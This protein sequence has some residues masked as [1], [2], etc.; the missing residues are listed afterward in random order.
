MVID[1]DEYSK[2]SA[3]FAENNH[4]GSTGVCYFKHS[5][6]ELLEFFGR[7]SGEERLEKSC[8]R[9]SAGSHKHIEINP[10]FRGMLRK[11]SG[12]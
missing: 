6:G 4:C 7:C 9:V 12:S 5:F 10:V 1:R 2:D 11:N 3:K 8:A